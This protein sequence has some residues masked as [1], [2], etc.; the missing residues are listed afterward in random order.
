MVYPH[1]SAAW[2]DARNPYVVYHGPV[3]VCPWFE[4][5]VATLELDGPHA[6]ITFEEAV[7]NDSGEPGLQRIYECKLS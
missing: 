7:Q 3:L 4:N 2:R 1:P 5:H 6:R